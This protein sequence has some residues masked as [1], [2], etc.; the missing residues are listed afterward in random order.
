MQAFADLAI[1]VNNCLNSP[2]GNKTIVK[3]RLHENHHPLGQYLEQ[4][5]WVILRIQFVH[6]HIIFCS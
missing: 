4:F 6:V 5:N 3:H 1:K 2:H